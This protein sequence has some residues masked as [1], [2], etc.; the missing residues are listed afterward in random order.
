MS[1]KTGPAA[2]QDD[3]SLS[4]RGF[5]ALSVATSV[6]LASGAARAAAAVVETDVQIKTADGMCDA[7]F[8]HPEGKGT[9]PAVLIWTDALGLRPA[10]RD[11]GKRL[12]AEGYAVLAPNPFYRSAKAPVFPNGLDF[13]ST[14]DRARLTE[15]RKPMTP[16]AVARDGTT[17]LAFLDAQAQ[18]NHKAK[19]GVVGYCMGG[20]MTLQ[21][22]AAV[23]TRVG[24]GGSFH[25]GGLVSDGPDS[26]H[27]LVSKIKARYYFAIAANDDQRQP[28]AKDKL[29]AAFAAASLPATIVVYDA[30]QHGWC[31]KD[32]TVY[33]EAQ[34]ERAWGELL[35]LY[36][37]SLV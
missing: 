13:S 2:G 21:T 15:L 3:Q 8:I 30:T 17:F 26:P 6:A 37:K 23:P 19:A 28:D 5:T 34:A 11:M 27:L 1:D 22:A 25:G 18:V 14:V 4:R 33:N 35:A 20:P 10:F 36:K 29:K 7:A 12:A 31:V 9:W 16:D 32:G 24:A